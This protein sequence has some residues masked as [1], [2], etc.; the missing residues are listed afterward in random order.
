MGEDLTL[1]VALSLVGLGAFAGG[2]ARGIGLLLN[3]PEQNGDTDPNGAIAP[4]VGRSPLVYLCSLPAVIAAPLITGSVTVG[5]VATLLSATIVATWH[6]RH[7]ISTERLSSRTRLQLG[8]TDQA[9]S[10]LR[11]TLGLH[12][13]ILVLGVAAGLLVVSS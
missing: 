6:Y 1:L 5:V 3:G 12:V 10:G 9:R 11:R 13:L 4:F 2:V 7:L 8:L